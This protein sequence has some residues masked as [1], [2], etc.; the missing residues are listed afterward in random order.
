[1]ASQ[2][3]NKP[4]E[5][6]I[7]E[8]GEGQFLVKYWWLNTVRGA[9]ALL[10]GLGLLFSIELV[11]ESA[12]LQAMTVQ[13]MGIYLLFS[14]VMSFI[15]G[16]SKRRKLGLWLVAGFLGLAGGIGLIFRP[17]LNSASSED[18]LLLAVVG[19]IMLLIGLIHI[20]G[21]FRLSEQM[22]RRWTGSHFFL[23]VVEIALGILALASIFVTVDI[24]RVLLSFWGLIAGIGL[25][26]DGQRIRRSA[27]V[28]RA[29]NKEG[30]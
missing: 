12:R 19:I 24:L 21:G 15:W 6:V 4:P 25:I 11:I 30:G 28:G 2:S 13:F 16:L 3:E 23:G 20:L 22:G 14:G 27:N 9:A 29:T 26:M 7:P 1:M 5:P 17:Y 10:M 8:P 18:L